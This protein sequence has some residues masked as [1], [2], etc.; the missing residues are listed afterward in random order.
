MRLLGCKLLAVRPGL[1]PRGPSLGLSA[2]GP[3]TLASVANGQK[4]NTNSA[5]SPR[6]PEMRTNTSDCCEAD[7]PG[8]GRRSE[9]PLSSLW[10]VRAVPERR[11][12]RNM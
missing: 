1:A 2:E 11:V 3:R 8:A 6:P 5:T 9:V 7:P 12:F 4:Q 10:G